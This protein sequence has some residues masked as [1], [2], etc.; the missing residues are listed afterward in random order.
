VPPIL[1]GDGA[2]YPFP[3]AT[4]RDRT[5]LRDRLRDAFLKPVPPGSTNAAS[6]EPQSVEELEIAVK[7]ANDKERLVGLLFAPFAS[8][9]G[10]SIISELI[11]HDPATPSK[12]H[13]AVSLY[14]ELGLVVVAL[15]VLMLVMAMRRKRLYLGMVMALYGLTVFNLH[16][17]G[18]GV[19]F[20][21]AGA[22]LLVRAYRAQRDLREATSGTAPRRSGTTAP[23]PR[24][25]KRYTPP[26]KRSSP[27]K[28]E[29]ERRAG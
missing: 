22:W 17:W 26:T 23:A 5:P 18:F 27:S 24:A 3:M 15:S 21:M 6:D 8:L 9:I 13:V 14:Y 2:R 29:N 1:R 7:F 25:S 16:Y 10:I 19:P 4:D 28:S 12:L 20:I 11:A